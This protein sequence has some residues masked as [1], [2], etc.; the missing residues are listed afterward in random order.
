MPSPNPISSN[1]ARLRS[2][3]G[4]TQI[5]L[6]EASGL[7]R[8]ALGRIERGLVTPRASTLERLAEA[9][10]VS[11]QQ[12]VAPARRL[13]RVRFRADKVIQAR[14]AILADVA[15]WLDGYAEVEAALGDERP[16]DL[17]QR[18]SRGTR[19]KRRR[20]DPVKEASRVRVALGIHDDPVRDISGL[21]EAH[22]VKLLRL[23][24]TT[25]TFFGLSV[26]PRDGGPAVVVNTWERISVERWIF[27]AAHELGHLVLHMDGDAFETDD[28]VERDDEEREADVFASH[29]LMPEGLFAREWDETAGLALLDRVLKVK[30][31]FRV[32]Y[33]TVLHRLVASE[34]AEGGVW[35]AFQQQ[36]KRRYGSTLRKVDEPN[37]M[38]ESDFGWNRA[39]EPERLSPSDFVEDRLHRLVRRAFEQGSISLGRAAELL[40]VEREDARQLARDWLD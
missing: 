22:G 32:S 1:L 14:E 33:K 40:R 7:S 34:R 23:V 31:I 12:L 38:T 28:S 16:C 35:R 30:R 2:A 10:E 37:R 19:V 13:G 15:D 24:R 4:L 36:H 6:A 29:L 8:L 18:P 9:L 20:P 17:L 26:G 21:L 11:L 39:D 27:S 25:D 3:A 5:E